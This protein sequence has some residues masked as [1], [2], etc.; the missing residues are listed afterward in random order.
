MNNKIRERANRE[1][2]R[3]DE[4]VHLFIEMQ[5][6]ELREEARF[7]TILSTLHNTQD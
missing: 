6:S 7:T 2:L 1:E 5:R 4:A 3:M